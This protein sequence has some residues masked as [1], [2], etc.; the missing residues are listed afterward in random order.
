MASTRVQNAITLNDKFEYFFARNLQFAF[1]LLCMLA[2]TSENVQSSGLCSINKTNSE[3]Y[4]VN[5]WH[6]PSGGEKWWRRGSKRNQETHTKSA[7]TG[8]SL[9]N[10]I[11]CC[12]KIAPS[13][14]WKFLTVWRSMIYLLM[15]LFLAFSLLPPSSSF[16]NPK[17]NKAKIING[18]S[19]HLGKCRTTTFISLSEWTPKEKFCANEKL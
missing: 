3:I 14:K 7:H 17:H 2:P 16:L 1:C 10:W 15:M 5:F 12:C 9:C 19:H 11:C 8:Q 13:L 6:L 4:W 18:F